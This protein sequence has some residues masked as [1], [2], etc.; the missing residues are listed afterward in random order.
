MF[1]V[2]FTV[3]RGIARVVN[4]GVTIF[5]SPFRSSC[6]QV[7]VRLSLLRFGSFCR[8]SRYLLDDFVNVHTD[9]ALSDATTATDAHFLSVGLK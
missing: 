2:T 8:D 3:S 9:G 5:A 6:V 7:F 4:P 1:R